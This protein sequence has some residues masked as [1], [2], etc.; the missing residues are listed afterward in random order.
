MHLKTLFFHKKYQEDI[1]FKRNKSLIF[2][3][4]EDVEA[5]KFFFRFYLRRDLDPAMEEQ[6]MNMKSDL[7][8]PDLLK[9]NIVLGTYATTAGRIDS[10]EDSLRD[11]R[12]VFLI[13]YPLLIYRICVVCHE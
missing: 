4:Q 7:I 9:W 13:A 8:I 10:F 2:N 5:V 11:L 1:Y 3:L 12:S 6:V